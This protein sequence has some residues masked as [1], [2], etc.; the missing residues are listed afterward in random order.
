M[1][2]RETLNP[3][4]EREKEREKERERERE[5]EKEREREWCQIVSQ[6]LT[7]SQNPQGYIFLA[8]VQLGSS[9]HPGGL[10]A[11]KPPAYM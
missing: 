5:R 10:L 1:P 3:V 9:I 6:V 7:L 4:R 8:F 11:Y 2:H